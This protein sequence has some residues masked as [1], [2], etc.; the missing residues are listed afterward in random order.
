MLSEENDVSIDDIQTS[1]EDVVTD[2]PPA[3]QPR[4]RKKKDDAVEAT[5][6]KAEQ[7]PAPAASGSSSVVDEIASMSD[8]DKQALLDA[9]GVSEAVRVATGEKNAPREIP[10]AIRVGVWPVDGEATKAMTATKAA[11]IIGI[12]VAEVM[13]YSVRA[14]RNVDGEPISEQA[15]LIVSLTDSTKQ[16]VPLSA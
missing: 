1:A 5:E 15:H 7:A 10:L 2:T 4:G 16:A 13:G 12:E 3:R 11:Q 8:N 14:P 9:L 6:P